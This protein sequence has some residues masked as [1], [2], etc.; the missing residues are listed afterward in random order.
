[1]RCAAE[2]R[3]CFLRD[4]Q[5]MIALSELNLK[6]NNWV[7]SG[8][9]TQKMLLV[10]LVRLANKLREFDCFYYFSRLLDLL[11]LS[12]IHQVHVQYENFLKLQA[13]LEFEF[14]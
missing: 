1:M 11:V 7:S 2:W 13:I 6:L 12:K 3:F 14:A 5:I 4:S 9:Q 8:N 10:L